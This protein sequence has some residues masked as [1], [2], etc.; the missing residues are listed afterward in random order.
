[1][2]GILILLTPT[3][4][5]G[6]LT[7]FYDVPDRCPGRHHFDHREQRLLVLL[8]I[9]IFYIIIGTFME[10]AGTDRALYSRLPAA[11]DTRWASIQ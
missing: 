9:G 6:Q 11:C 7:A 10:S 3:L 2:T 1:M 5:F 4:A 8:L